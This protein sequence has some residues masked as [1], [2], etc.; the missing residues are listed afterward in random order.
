M[1]PRRT[2]TRGTVY[3]F[4]KPASG[5]AD[6]T[7]TAKLTPADGFDG[8]S[9]GI[10][11]TMSAHVALVGDYHP[12]DYAAD[13]QGAVYVFP[14]PASG[15]TDMSKNAALT[16]ADGDGMDDFGVYTAMNN[17]VII[18]GRPGSGAYSGTYQKGAVYV[19]T[20]PDGTGL[21]PRSCIPVEDDLGLELPCAAYGDAYYKVG[22]AFNPASGVFAPAG[23]TVL[24]N[25]PDPQ[26]C[27]EAGTNLGL[28]L[29]C[30]NCLGLLF[31]VGL[32]F[33]PRAGGWTLRPGSIL[34]Q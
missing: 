14:K 22:L 32:D 8:Q 15:W 1:S 13:R 31:Q 3:L 33:D 23:V 11:V 27:I 19:F 16:A 34:F 18:A 25:P 10:S 4:E 6:M 2:V 5:W 26:C 20:D 17:P 9:F 29:P 24:D 12:Q 30:V 21:C 28:T 7:Q